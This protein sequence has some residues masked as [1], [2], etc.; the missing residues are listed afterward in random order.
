MA[1]SPISFLVVG[2]LALLCSCCSALRTATNVSYDSRAIIINGE[3]RVLFSGAIHY[4]RSTPEMWPDLIRKAKEGGIDAIETYVFWD[5][6]EPRRGKYDF[7]GHLDLIRFMKTVEAAG[8]YAI[9]RI[10][11]YVCAE[12]SYGSTHAMVSTVIPFSQTIQK[13]LKC[14]LKTG[15]DGNLNQPKWGHLKQLHEAIKSVQNVLTNGTF[16]TLTI[17]AMELLQ[18][19]CSELNLPFVNQ[20]TRYVNNAT[21]DSVC[22]LSNQNK[23]ADANIDLQQDGKYTVPAW[24]VS[25]LAGCNKEIYNTAKVNA[26]TS[27]MVKKPSGAINESTLLS[28]KW[29]SEPMKD[30][31]GGK[32]D[33]L[34]SRL[35]EQKET[36]VDASDYLWYTT[37]I[38]I[39]ETAWTNATLRVNT[40]GHVLHA[41]V[42]QELIGTS[43]L[44][45]YDSF[46]DLTPTGIVGGPIQ[47]ISNGKAIKDI[48]SN[49]WFYKTTFKAPSGTDP[50]VVDLQGMGKGHAWVNGQS[51]GRFWPSFLAD[52]NG[53]SDTCDYRGQYG[54]NKCLRNCGNPSQRWYHIPRSFLNKKR[55]TLVLFEEMGGNPSQVS[56]LTVT[57]GTACGN[58]YEGNTLQLSCQGGRTISVIQFASFGDPQGTCGSFKKGSCEAANS[59]S[60]VEKAC[61]GQQTC[62]L[63]VSEATF[64][65]SKCDNITKRLAVQAVC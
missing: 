24:S 45:N 56:F 19:Q 22:F 60:A 54:S 27:V 4:P 7:S 8:L 12:W 52:K 47:L 25:I 48:S 11:P 30:A 63:N 31:L 40:R 3:R 65:P 28:W 16:A 36:T 42:N 51:I 10:G 20:L 15:L 35:L 41:Y 49:I 23:T 59:F 29:V 34:A 13:V 64:G 62:S 55:N 57:V 26:Q 37:T 61:I 44:Q 5:R 58:A 17:T 14:G 38:N 9:L 33:F 43:Y 21:G 32:G 2:G 39:N 6:H 50:V 18:R 1:S 53:C 46:F